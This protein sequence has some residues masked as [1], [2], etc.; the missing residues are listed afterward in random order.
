MKTLCT[1]YLIHAS[2]SYGINP[3][4]RNVVPILPVDIKHPNKILN[5]IACL[6]LTFSSPNKAQ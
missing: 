1:A 6:D 3:D 4:F 2:L 5:N